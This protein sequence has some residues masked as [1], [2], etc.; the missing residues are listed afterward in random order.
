MGQCQWP[1][2]TR[3]EV[4]NS[5]AALGD[6]SE[7]VTSESSPCESRQHRPHSALTWR[8]DWATL[9]YKV[10]LSCCRRRRTIVVRDGAST[11]HKVCANT[12]LE[13]IRCEAQL[14]R[15]HRCHVLHTEGGVSSSRVSTGMQPVS[16]APGCAIYYY[17]WRRSAL[18]KTKLFS[19]IS[20]SSRHVTRTPST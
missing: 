11:H 14:W 17:R 5:G 16:M 1:A 19:A 13:A 2:T 7:A 20:G 15:L 9:T 3:T 8:P 18:G 4:S 10:S 12:N 6:G